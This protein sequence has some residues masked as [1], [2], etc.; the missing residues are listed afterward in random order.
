MKLLAAL[1]LCREF[2]RLWR[3]RRRI[4]A[5]ARISPSQFSA[6]MTAAL[7]SPYLGGPGARQAAGAILTGYWRVVLMCL[8]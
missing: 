8:R 7:D 5:N 4:Q 6:L 3:E 1:D 2:P